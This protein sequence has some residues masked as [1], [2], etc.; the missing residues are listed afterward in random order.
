MCDDESDER[1]PAE[2]EGGGGRG[3]TRRAFVWAVCAAGMLALGGLGTAMGCSNENA[4]TWSER[5]DRK[6]EL[7]HERNVR[8]NRSKRR[9][10]GKTS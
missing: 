7:R 1:A 3:L 5:I 9:N 8:R 4:P 2:E 10:N 6:R